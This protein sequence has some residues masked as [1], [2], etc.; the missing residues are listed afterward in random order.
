MPLSYV[1][2][3]ITK[4]DPVMLT[5]AALATKNIEKPQQTIVG[6]VYYCLQSRSEYGS[7]LLFSILRLVC[8]PPIISVISFII[9]VSMVVWQY[10]T[11]LL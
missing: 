2:Q 7:L 8:H 9:F 4:F 3:V 6:E 10:C 1:M 5:A 11:R